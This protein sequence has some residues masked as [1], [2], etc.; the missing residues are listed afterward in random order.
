MLVCFAISNTKK[1]SEN[2][3]LIWDAVYCNRKEMSRYIFVQD[4]RKFLKLDWKG[5]F[6]L[7]ECLNCV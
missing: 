4:E 6:F 7:N 5:L 1:N 2:V 3:N